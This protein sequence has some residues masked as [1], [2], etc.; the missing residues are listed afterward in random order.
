[1]KLSENPSSWIGFINN[2]IMISLMSLTHI[3]SVGYQTQ[4][5][6]LLRH[7]YRSKFTNVFYHWTPF[8][9]SHHLSSDDS[10]YFYL[11][12]H[13]CLS[14]AQVYFHINMAQL[15]YTFSIFPGKK[16]DLVHLQSD[17]R[18]LILM[19]NSS[20]VFIYYGVEFLIKNLQVISHRVLFTF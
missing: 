15:Q 20:K 19:M 17:F 18:L 16:T 11:T 14:P 6:S 1:M 13:A 10:L 8:S 3:K 2:F 7:L 12:L 4:S 9:W 5:L